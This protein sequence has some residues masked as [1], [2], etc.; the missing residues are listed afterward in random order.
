VQDDLLGVQGRLLDPE[1]EAPHREEVLEVDAEAL[2]HG[3]ELRA[4]E[5]R[6]EVIKTRC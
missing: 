1:G 2:P 3:A 6:G 5:L 4:E